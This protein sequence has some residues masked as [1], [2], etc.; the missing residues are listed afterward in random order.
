M[1][2][3]TRSSSLESELEN[4]EWYHI[5]KDIREVNEM[6]N[7]EQDTRLHEAQ[8]TEQAV[9]GPDSLDESAEDADLRG[10]PPP[11]YK[12]GLAL[13]IPAPPVV[14]GGAEPQ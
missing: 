9:Q 14:P 5:F 4:E 6:E 2:T 10:S 3:P 7:A 1:S 12:P 8:Q 11:P 13:P